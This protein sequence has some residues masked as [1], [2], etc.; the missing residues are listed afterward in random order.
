MKILKKIIREIRRQR[1]ELKEQSRRQIEFESDYIR[2]QREE[3]LKEEGIIDLPEF[4]IKILEKNLLDE[5]NL[6]IIC[7]NNMEANE[8]VIILPCTHIFHEDCI[9]K[10]LKNKSTCPICQNEIK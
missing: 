8:I 6:C 5:K 2:R 4:N 10:W 1:D 3:Y 9:T 7:L